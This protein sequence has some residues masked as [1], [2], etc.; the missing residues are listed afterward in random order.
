MISLIAV[1]SAG[2]K[3]KNI[4]GLAALVLIYCT[5]FY[6]GLR[7]SRIKDD[8]PAAAGQNAVIREM[9]Q[10]EQQQDPA[11]ASGKSLARE[12]APAQ[13]GP[14]AFPRE[15]L[16]DMTYIQE[17]KHSVAGPWHQWDVLLAARPYGWKTMLEWADALTPVEIKDLD[18]VIVGNLGFPTHDLIDQVRK[19]GSLSATPEL[20]A[21]QGILSLAGTSVTLGLPVM[22]SLVNQTRTLKVFSLFEDEELMRRWIETA[23]R[24]SFGTPDA[25]KLA[26]PL[27]SKK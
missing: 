2:I 7:L 21:E 17:L 27:A 24:R 9:L 16:D 15:P 18:Q 12:G 20:K 8:P 22:V 3:E 14:A 26:R 4:P 19:Y 10:A 6:V 23:V 1:F 5:L 11:S 13:S 25:M